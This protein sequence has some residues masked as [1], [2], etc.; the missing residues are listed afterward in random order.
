MTNRTAIYARTSP[1]CP[2]SLE[3]QLA[4]LKCVAAERGW[5]VEHIFTDRPSAVRKGHDRRPGELALIEAIRSGSIGKVLVWSLCRVGR[6]LTE[7]VGF[8]ETCRAR[9]VAL[10]LHEQQIDTAISNGVSLLDVAPLMVHHLRQSR[11]SKILR[12]QA[13]ARAL[14]IRFGRPPIAKQKVDRAKQFLASGKGVRQVARMAG[15][16]PAS[17]ARIK[18]S[19]TSDGVRI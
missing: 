11:R 19:L 7:L 18:T 9:G 2:L 4:C 5:T 14:S 15:I 6:S 1:D 17:A 12:G 8:L 10:Y 13:S 3:E 16:S